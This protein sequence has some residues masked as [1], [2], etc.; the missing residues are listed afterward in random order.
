MEE[1]QKSIRVIKKI[2]PDAPHKTLI[3]IDA[4]TGQ[5]GLDQ[6]KIFKELVDVN[7]VIITTLDGSSKGGILIAVAAETGIPIYFVGVGEKAEDM[8]IFKAEDFAK[9]LLDI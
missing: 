2:Y 1:L 8:D 4:T 6:V 9:G 7:G 3:T 5:N